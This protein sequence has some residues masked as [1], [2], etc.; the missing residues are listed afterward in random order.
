MLAGPYRN[1]RTSTPATVSSSGRPAI[2]RR[3]HRDVQAYFLFCVREVEQEGR[4]VV[5]RIARERRGQMQN[6]HAG[7]VSVTAGL[8]EHT[9]RWAIRGSARTANSVAR[10]RPR[11]GGQ[12]GQRTVLPGEFER[13]GMGRLAERFAAD[14]VGEQARQRGADRR[15]IGLGVGDRVTADLGQR[16]PVRGEHGGPARHRLEDR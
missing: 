16:E 8:S 2:V 12:V 9:R 1:R 14:R 11:I 15:R 3:Q 7:S 6:T 4:D 10:N 13:A 5:P